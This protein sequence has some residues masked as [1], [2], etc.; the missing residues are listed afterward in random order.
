MLPDR[1]QESIYQLST[2]A[3]TFNYWEIL[4]ILFLIFKF[5]IFLS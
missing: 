1:E 5:Y 3:I 4:F 2:L